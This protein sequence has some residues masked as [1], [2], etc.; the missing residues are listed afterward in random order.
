MDH[1]ATHRELRQF[2]LLVGGIFA[3]IGVWPPLVHS[4]PA[5][6]WAVILGGALIVPGAIMPWVLAPVH[7]AWMWIGHILGWINTRILLGV[8]FYGLVT[9]IGIIF[10]I[11]GKDEMRRA[12]AESNSTYRVLKAPRP[13]SHMKY[14][15]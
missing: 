15:F 5:R 11:M 13:R 1:A 2:G 6:L 4:E 8:V 9:P 12:F 7:K 3:V 14:Q 10:R